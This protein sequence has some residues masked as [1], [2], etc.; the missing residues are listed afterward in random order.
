MNQNRPYLDL[1]DAVDSIKFIIEQELYSRSVYNVVTIN[2]SVGHI[3]E[4]IE[5]QVAGVSIQYVDSEIM[6]QLSYHVDSRRFRKLGFQFKGDLERGIGD[7]IRLLRQARSP[8]L[9]S[10]ES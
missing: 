7:T 8:K 9:E 6:N 4:T 5:S 2:T 3:I 10:T 1:S